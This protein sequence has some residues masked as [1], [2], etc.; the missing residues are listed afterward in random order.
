MVLPPI[1]CKLDLGLKRCHLGLD[2]TFL[3]KTRVQIIGTS[4]DFGEKKV[5]E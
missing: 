4:R 2:I 3:S 5:L 1:N